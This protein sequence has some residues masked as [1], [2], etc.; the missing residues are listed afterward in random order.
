MKPVEPIPVNLPLGG[1]NVDN[2]FHDQPKGTTPEALNVRP[3]D[4]Q[5]GR[6]RLSRR[7]GQ[8]RP[9]T[10]ALG[11]ASI[12]D[13]NS[14]VITLDQAAGTGDVWTID[15]TTST[16][17][18]RDYDDG[19]EAT[20]TG[21][22]ATLA[23]AASMGC[24]D[25]DGNFYVASVAANALQLQKVTPAYVRSWGVTHVT[26]GTGA[27]T[28]FG[29][30]AFNGVLY[31]WL[32][33]NATSSLTTPGLYRYRLADGAPMDSG[34]WLTTND[35]IG[36]ATGIDTAHQNIAVAGNILGMACGLSGALVFQ[37][38]DVVSGEVVKTTTLQ[39]T[40]ETYP[41]KV[42]SDNGGN[43]YILTN[44]KVGNGTTGGA[45]NPSKLFKV[46]WS[47]AIVWE[48][49]GTPA[50][51]TMGRDIAYDP[52]NFRLA[53]VGKN[54]FGLTESPSLLTIGAISGAVQGKAQP[55]DT[56]A[57][58][59]RDTW[60]AVSATG[61]EGGT[62]GSLY[63]RRSI[64]AATAQNDLIKFSGAGNVVWGKDTN[65]DS[66]TSTLWVVASGLNVTPAGSPMQSRRTTR[67]YGICGGSLVRYDRNIVATVSS[68]FCSGGAPVVFSTYLLGKFYY[69]DGTSYPYVDVFTNTPGT[70][71]ATSGALPT[72]PNGGKC[73]LVETWRE[74]LVMA[75]MLTNPNQIFASA[76]SEPQNWNL[77]PRPTLVTQ[78]FSI[79]ANDQVN[80]MVPWTDD[81]MLLLCDHSLRLL[82]G[83]PQAGGQ[84]DLISDVTGGAFGRAWCK[85]PSGGLYFL[86]SRG[87][88]WWLESGST[89]PQRLSVAIDAELRNL[90]FSAII[91]RMA[92]DDENQGFHLWLSP[93]DPTEEC[94]HYWWDSDTQVR[95][96]IDVVKTPGSWWKDQYANTYLN[97]LAVHV[98]DGDDP[99]DRIILQGG[100]DGRIRAFSRT[101]LKDDTFAIDSSVLIGPIVDS[102]TIKLTDI[103][104]YMGEDSEKVTWGIRSGE[105]VES[106]YLNS[107][108][109]SGVFVGGRNRSPGVRARGNSHF[110]SL[111]GPDRWT[112]DKL[113]IVAREL[114]YPAGRVW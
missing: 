94:F 14:A 64:A 60:L 93:I 96:R 32:V 19:S 52:V 91:A 75:G 101:A 82:R 10:D 25:E 28:V 110:I 83:D 6:R 50:A 2:A 106:A 5:T 84:V 95:S 74:R 29:V 59:A 11:A 23:S 63:L 31:V 27:G 39:A 3:Y 111:S 103:H 68:T 72:D 42:V 99:D 36:S 90:D 56:A 13:L 55:P 108:S 107:D 24:V 102:N 79:S 1:I 38:I 21:G 71:T 65:V 81:T 26:A 100:R 41:A 73:R 20:I 87:A 78:A 18:I 98:Y 113:M 16:V 112:M 114:P 44:V 54:L 48:F 30:A 43:F 45:T 76:V 109:Q 46:S 62:A 17:T 85:D 49:A 86:G 47:G 58:T 57:G 69:V 4:C 88:V 66:P 92:W 77:N 51:T 22:L 40:F 34:A 89:V 53:V 70:L 97:P 61:I 35:G 9:V 7:A 80:G 15:D 12:Q 37:Q 67:A 33:D 105:S 8:V 104:A